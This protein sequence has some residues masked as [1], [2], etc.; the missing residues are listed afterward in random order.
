MASGHC[1]IL[2]LLLLLL[3]HTILLSVYVLKY[4][5]LFPLPT[6]ALNLPP[7]ALL[8]AHLLLHQGGRSRTDP[9][10]REDVFLLKV[11]ALNRR[12][13]RR[14]KPAAAAADGGADGAEGCGVDPF[15][16]EYGDQTW[17]TRSQAELAAHRGLAAVLQPSWKRNPNDRK[18]TRSSRRG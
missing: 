15:A 10:L 13:G 1:L 18:P 9:V 14:P 12:P 5:Y 11:K 2:L 8:S 4:E 3:L 16:P 7:L 17:H 6:P